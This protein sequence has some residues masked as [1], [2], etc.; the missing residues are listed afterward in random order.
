LGLRKDEII[1][2][3]RTMR[4]RDHVIFFY[5][6][7]E[8]K[9]YVLFTYLKAGL[10]KGEAVAYVVSQETPEHLRQAMQEYGIDVKR[11][12]ASGA[13]KVLDY[14]GW[15]IIA[16]GFDPEKTMS[17]WKNLVDESKK[18]GFKGLRITGEMSCFFDYELVKELMEYENSLR[19]TLSVPIMAICA[20]DQALFTRQTANT[21]SVE[22]LLSLMSAHS[23]AI[24]TGHVEGVVKTI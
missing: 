19:R 13:L 1:D 7:R 6:G 11:Y 23:S 10:D 18:K 8:D 22:V 14:K 15:Y 3:V 20:Y 4:S 12:E 17:L 2:F 5:T 16:G 9:Y 21:D 24:I